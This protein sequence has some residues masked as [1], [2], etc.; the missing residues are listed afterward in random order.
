MLT[1][2]RDGMWAT[3]Q[4]CGLCTGARTC[5]SRRLEEKITLT[6]QKCVILDAQKQE[7]ISKVKTDLG[8]MWLPTMPCVARNCYSQTTLCGCC[9]SLSLK[10]PPCR[11]PLS[12]SG[13]V[14]GPFFVHT[15]NTLHL[16][17]KNKTQTNLAYCLLIRV[18][19]NFNVGHLVCT[20]PCSLRMIQD[21]QNVLSLDHGFS[22]LTLLTCC[23][24]PFFVVR[25]CPV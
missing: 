15:P 1:A 3:R 23:I 22:T 20:F 10:S 13:L 4:L 8:Q 14:S 25:D 21:P 7:T 12:L 16:Y 9:C 18:V 11:L 17:L 2:R 6:F 19:I 24:R 5:P